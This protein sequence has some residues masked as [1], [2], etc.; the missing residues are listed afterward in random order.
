MCLNKKTQKSGISPPPG[1]DRK[2]LS[3]LPESETISILRGEGIAEASSTQSSSEDGVLRGDLS[4]KDS[5]PRKVP[6]ISFVTDDE[7]EEL[8][9]NKRVSMICNILNKQ[10]RMAKLSSFECQN[11]FL[12]LYF[13]D[14]MEVTQA[15]VT[16]LKTNG[17]WAYVPKF[18]FRA[19]IYLIDKKGDLQIDP[20]LLKLKPSSG[21]DPTAGFASSTVVRRFPSG[22]CCLHGS[23]DDEYLE[24]SVP[25]PNSEAI[26]FR[27]LQVVTVSIFCDDW[28]TK[29][30]VPQPRLH[31]QSTSSSSSSSK[32]SKRNVKPTDTNDV[33]KETRNDSNTSK[34]YRIE[35]GETAEPS[36]YSEII[37]IQT[38][39]DLDVNYRFQDKDP[40]KT[41]AGESLIPGRIV[42][43]AFINPDTRSAQQEVSIQ[44]AAEA[45]T[46]RRNQ[47]MANRSKKS[48]F[49]TTRQIERDVTSRM[50]RLAA[51]K[52]NTKK[53]KSK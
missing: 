23:G 18:D 1:F 40:V 48:E 6:N 9:S 34:K 28:N 35:S 45:A 20:T 14:H 27:V 49:E 2:V 21:M 46:E 42:F 25:D 31:L 7:D 41:P 44:E 38:P 33:H 39:P 36:L 12:S 4:N 11:L 29:S 15:V 5:N 22:K 51:N 52:R 37:N 3:A 53:G 47:A 10:N 16:N 13:K 43:N 17:F 8:Y 50:Q 19:P 24:L 26:S 30:R 32:M